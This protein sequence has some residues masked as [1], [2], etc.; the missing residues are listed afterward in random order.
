MYTSAA[1]TG[2][3]IHRAEAK[4]NAQAI[5]YYNVYVFYSSILGYVFDATIFDANFQGIRK[6]NSARPNNGH[7]EFIGNLG[8]DHVH[9]LG[10]FYRETSILF[11]NVVWHNYFFS[12]FIGVRIHFVANGLH[13]IR[14]NTPIISRWEHNH[15]LR[16]FGL[17]VSVELLFVLWVSC[18]AMDASVRDFSF[19]VCF[20]L[21]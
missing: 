7:H 17:F 11:S 21:L 20:L 2:G 15:A 3:K 10:A 19:Q 8:N 4:T 5:F 6:S 16:S 18:N 13:F 1:N 14:S 9:M 12:C